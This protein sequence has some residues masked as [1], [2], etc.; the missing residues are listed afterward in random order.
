MSKPT[1]AA[2]AA[3][4]GPT[5]WRY[6]AAA[7]FLHWASAALICA[8]AALGWY[9]MTIEHTPDG[10]ASLALHKSLGCVLALLVLIRVLWRLGHRPVA[11]AAKLPAWHLKLAAATQGLLYLMM[12]LM[13]LTGYLGASYSKR[14][15]ALF[16]IATPRWALPDHDRAEQFFDI[17]GTL[18][19]VLVAL[20]AIHTAAALKDRLVDR[21]GVF[22]RMWFKPNS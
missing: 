10:D 15:V 12:V 16:G 20:V 2:A 3:P 13:P 17:H 4:Q 21:N 22:Q 8:L 7:R 9:M 18:I 19:W 5:A 14:G 6:D 11:L 1:I